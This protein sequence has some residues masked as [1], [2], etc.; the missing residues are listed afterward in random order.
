M[1][2]IL[3]DQESR[4]E[5]IPPLYPEDRARLELLLQTTK[6]VW[7][8]YVS[9]SENPRQTAS[10]NESENGSQRTLPT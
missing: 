9:R 8:D 6:R 5:A 1:R 3:G 4:R 10:E 2:E 7:Q